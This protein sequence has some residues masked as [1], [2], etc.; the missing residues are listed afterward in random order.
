MAGTAEGSRAPGVPRGCAHTVDLVV[1]PQR[2]VAS[3]PAGGTDDAGDAPPRGGARTK[4][5][6]E[7]L[8]RDAP[9]ARR[10]AARAAPPDRLSAS[11]P[12]GGLGRREATAH[13]LGTLQGMC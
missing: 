5:I 7:R 3:A 11:Y 13:D 4:R 2:A 12:P 9:G 1:R 6:R 10:S 8:R